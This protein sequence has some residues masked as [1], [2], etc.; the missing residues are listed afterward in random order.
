MIHTFQCLS[1]GGVYVE[2]STD[3]ISYAHACG[4]LPATKKEPTRERPDKR[5]ENQAVE[6]GG[7]V[8]GI[9]SEGKGV[10][11]LSNSKLK[12]PQWI[13]KLK[14]EIDKRREKDAASNSD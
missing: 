9:R 10:K 11:C 8:T 4:P 13:T 5:D 1:C 12:E 6:R 14:R 3:G 2:G 7:R